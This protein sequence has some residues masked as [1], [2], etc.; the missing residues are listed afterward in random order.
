MRFLVAQKPNA[1]F[2]GMTAVNIGMTALYVGMTE[3]YV[4][5]TT[6][7]KTLSFRTVCCEESHPATWGDIEFGVRRSAKG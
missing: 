7:N 2:V 1:R 4:G 6:L 5:M 3:V